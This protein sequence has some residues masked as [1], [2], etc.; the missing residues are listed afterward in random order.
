MK[1]KL[2]AQ[3][4]NDEF[5]ELFNPTNA[6][7]DLEGYKLSK[8]TKTGSSESTLVSAAKFSGTIQAHGYF[9]IAHPGY[10]DKI[11]ADLPYSGSTYYISN[12]NTVFLYDKDGT[13]LDKVGFGA[14]SDFERSPASNP[15]ANQSIEKDGFYRHG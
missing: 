11:S 7:I 3:I 9:L 15:D 5:I 8:K 13:L 1:S 6:P 10:K 4:S 14:A 2:P 12:D